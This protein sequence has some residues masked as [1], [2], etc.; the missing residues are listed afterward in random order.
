MALLEIRRKI[1]GSRLFQDLLA[2]LRIRSRV[3]ISDLYGSSKSLFLSVLREGL[4]EPILAV[5]AQPREAEEMVDDL[6]S[7][8]EEAK[9]FLPLF[10]RGGE[11]EIMGE[12]IETLWLLSQGKSLVLVTTP[13]VLAEGITPCEFFSRSVIKIR[14]GQRLDRE[15]LIRRLVEMGFENLPLVEGVG[16]FSIRGGIV[17]IFPY[18][19]EN[20]L[21]IELF[22][23]RVESMRYFEVQNQRSVGKIDEG[24]ILPRDDRPAQSSASLGDYFPSGSLLFLHESL[25]GSTVQAN[26]LRLN[27]EGRFRVIEDFPLK[28]YREGSI[29]IGAQAQEPLNSSLSLLGERLKGNLQKGWKNYILC[30]NRGQAQ[31]LEELLDFPRGVEISVGSLHQGFLLAELG[32][33]VFTD[34]EIFNRYHL[35]RRRRRYKEGVTIS[36]WQS[37]SEGDW[38]VHIDYGIG[39]FLGLKLIETNGEKMECL[40]LVYR[41]GDRLY[42]PIDQLDRVQKYVGKEGFVPQLSRMG[43]R[44]WERTRRKAK[45]AIRDMA[46]ELIEIYAER[47]AKSGFTFSP[48]TEWQRELEASFIY[49]ETPDQFSAVEAIKADMEASAPMDRLVC[50][51]VGYGKTEVAVRAAFKAVVDGKQVAVLIPTTVLAQ[52]HLITFRERLAE[53]PV[54]VEMLSRFRT[55]SQQREILKDLREGKVDILIGTHR[56]I[57]KDVRFRDLGLVIIDEEQRFGVAHKEKLKRLRRL[58]DVLTLTA[59]PIPRTLHLSLMG[60]RDMARIDTPPR[61]RLSVETHIL[62]FNPEVISEAILREVERDGQVYF[63]HNRVETIENMAG[64]L[65]RLLPQIRF[66]IAHG[67]ME[68]R[69]LERVML[70][71]LKGR[72]D[73]L[74]TT[75]IIESGIDI[76][77]VNTIIINRA[78]RFG[79]AQLYQLRGRVGRSNQQAYAYLLVPPW[80]RL[81]P[82][83]RKRLKAIEQ[84]TELGSGFDLAMRD[85]EIRGAGNILGPQQH[86]FIEAVGFNLYCRL[87]EEAVRELKGEGNIEPPK[88]EVNLQKNLFFPTYYIPSPDQRVELYQRL[89]KSKSVAE[90]EELKGEVQ[91]RYGRLPEEVEPLFDRA[92]VALLAGKK[93][94]SQV[95]LRERKLV[96]SYENSVLPSQEEMKKLLRLPLPVEFSQGERLEINFPLNEAERKKWIEMAKNILQRWK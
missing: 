62:P 29:P 54:R 89:A 39:K 75:S 42:V 15:E 44:D 31:R 94:V 36:S 40:N 27:G 28:G 95:W 45:K 80:R 17:D 63:V 57:Q 71:F 96:F 23:D 32:I 19:G 10:S 66:G 20:P 83:A 65:K 6:R 14:V 49:E 91:D 76:P 55:R 50:G 74:I 90:V 81:T 64:F 48:D 88:A 68:E 73:C 9:V 72:F 92:E 34:H 56:L 78:D 51:D 58:V 22:G 13:E 26:G 67:Q 3:A 79:L 4:G 93:G 8:G 5:V 70:D 41:D 87:I 46:K 43:G 53:Y 21:R 16:D 52:Q 84:F 1:K 2:L 69:L 12:R 82:T 37:L 60:A 24:F 11:P 47:K 38:V 77:N 59:T 61:E 35:R 85:L 18:G 33:S 7:F 86:G 25:R 30:E